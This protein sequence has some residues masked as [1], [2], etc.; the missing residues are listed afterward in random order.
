MCIGSAENRRWAD[1][2]ENGPSSPFASF[3]DI[4]WSPPKEDLRDKVLLPILGDQYGRVLENG[5]IRV[6]REG[7]AF[8]ARYHD[9][10]L[11]LAPKSWTGVLEPLRARLADA[12]DD[13]PDRIELES[14]LTAISH[15]PSR[16]ERDLLRVQERQREKEVIKRR[17][18]ALLDQSARAR[19][20]LEASLA[21]LNGRRGEPSSFDRLG[22]A[23]RGD[24][25]L[26]CL[27]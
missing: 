19:E 23:R 3:F 14:I 22:G 26:P 27:P 15:L 25:E 6:E 8:V 12:P 10:V 2:L 9:H 21:E 5:E 16:S 4:D 24:R 20:G 7:G 13:D 11:P 17:L 18:G 1:V